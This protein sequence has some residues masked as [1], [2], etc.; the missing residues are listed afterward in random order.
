MLLFVF[1]ENEKAKTGTEEKKG[2]RSDT[3]EKEE[4]KKP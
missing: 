1:H 2:W 4:E 3:S